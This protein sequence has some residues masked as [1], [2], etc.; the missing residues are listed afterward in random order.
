MTEDA[1]TPR[2]HTLQAIEMMTAWAEGGQGTAFLQERIREHL[3]TVPEGPGALS[4]VETGLTEM[5]I[6]V[7]N[8]AGLLLLALQAKTG[9]RPEETLHE[10]SLRLQRPRPSSESGSGPGQ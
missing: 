4:S 10:L 6:G 8:L 5:L 9:A 1:A 3:L 7:T 2:R